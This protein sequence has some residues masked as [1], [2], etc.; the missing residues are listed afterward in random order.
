MMRRAQPWLGTLVEMSVA[1]ALPERAL[2]AAIAGAYA[3]VALVQRLMSF[4]DAASDVSRLNRAAPG[5]RLT[6][7][8][9]TWRVL[10]LAQQVAAA[11]DG[12][13]NIACAPQLVT[14][15]CLPAPP[16]PPMPPLQR[17][18]QTAERRPSSASPSVQAMQAARPAQSPSPPA[19]DPGL[20]LLDLE[21]GC[22]VR[23]LAPGWIDLGGIAKG[24]AVDLAIAA[25][26]DAGVASACVN[27][28]GDL[29]AL[30]E[31]AWP[32]A[33][34]DPRAPRRAGAQLHVRDEA[35]ATSAHYFSAR[36]HAGVDVSAL[37]DGRDGRPVA[38]QASVSVRAASC[39]VADA[40]TKVVI[41]SGDPHHRALRAMAASAMIL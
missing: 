9:H 5:A 8:V 7:H 38:G 20:A 25:L 28:G 23:K 22:G 16:M 21:D 30:G 1:D 24:Y 40:L 13:F 35:M 26:R 29:R 17:L 12:I 37:V 39:A 31:A 41:A 3:E 14:W 6:V 19:Y 32:V 33:V 15:G 18:R 27:A 36:R 10:R 2:Y 11:S 4:H 34:R